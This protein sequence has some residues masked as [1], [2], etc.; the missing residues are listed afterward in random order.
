MK[1]FYLERE[2]FDMIFTVFCIP[3]LILHFSITTNKGNQ[4]TRDWRTEFNIFGIGFS[5]SIDFW[6]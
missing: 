4:T 1:T 3:S 2:K 5:V 6:R